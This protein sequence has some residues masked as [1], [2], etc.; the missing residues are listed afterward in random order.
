METSN[1]MYIMQL[2]I[3][4]AS[5]SIIRLSYLKVYYTSNFA[6]LTFFLTKAK[7]NMWKAKSSHI[8]K[9]KT[10]GLSL[11]PN[12]PPMQRKKIQ[13][14]Q[15]QFLCCVPLCVLRFS[16][17]NVLMLSKQFKFSCLFFCTS[18]FKKKLLNVC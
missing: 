6:T 5:L 13:L 4:A 7:T 15:A 16:S 8:F 2:C 14:T 12:P 18:I 1:V 10:G 17:L 11:P 3:P 9:S